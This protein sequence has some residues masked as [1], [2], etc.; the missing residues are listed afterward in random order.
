M[1]VGNRV[2]AQSADGGALPTLYAATA[3]DVR[4]DSFIGP[5][6]AMWRGTPGPS[7]RAPWTL[8]DRAGERLW[9]ASEELTGVAYDELKA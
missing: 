3:P 4:P 1:R 8:N 5:S 2:F 9:A 7:K 6:F